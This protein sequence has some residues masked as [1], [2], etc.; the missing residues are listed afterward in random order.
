MQ[1]QANPCQ[2]SASSGIRR[3]RRMGSCLLR[4]QAL[5]Q[6]PPLSVDV[7]AKPSISDEVIRHGRKDRVL[8]SFVRNVWSQRMRCFPCHTPDEIDASD[9]KHAKPQTD[10]SRFRGA[11]RRTHGHF[12][13]DTGGDDEVAACQQSQAFQ[14]TVAAHQSGSADPKPPRCSSHAR[15]FRRRTTTESLENHRRSTPCLTWAD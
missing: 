6:R 8:D 3:L 13:G 5:V 4:R 10:S 2:D 15:R 7:L 1:W 9:P 12:Q 11:I 14:E